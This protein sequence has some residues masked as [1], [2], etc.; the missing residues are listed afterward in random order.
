MSMSMLRLAVVLACCGFCNFCVQSDDETANPAKD[1]NRLAYLDECN[2]WYPHTN[3][4][5]LITPQWVGEE[6]VEAV[7]VLGIDDMRDT[8]KYEQYLRPILN[9]LKQIDGRAPVS[10]MTCDVKPDDPQL[11]SWLGEGLS[12]ECHTID[13]PCPIL[14]GGDG[15]FA[16]AK[17]TYDRC[18][19]L[20]GTIPGNKP[21]AFRTPCCDSLNTVS[22]RFFAEIFDGTNENGNFLQIDSSVFTFFTSE[23][24]SLPKELVL[25]ANGKERFWKYLPK[26]NKYGGNV[27]N[28]FVNYIKNYPYP[29]VINNSCWEIPC[30]APSDWSAQHL[31]GANNPTTV[32]DWKA[33]IDL[34]VHKQGCFSLVFHPHG[35]ISPEQV[36]EMIDHAV[37]KHGKKVKFLNFREVAERLNKHLLH[38][39]DN[40]RQLDEEY[41]LVDINDDG[42]IDVVHGGKGRMG[43]SEEERSESPPMMWT[44]NTSRWESLPFPSR[45]VSQMAGSL[46][47]AD[48]VRFMTLGAE[49]PMCILDVGSAKDSSRPWAELWRFDDTWK[50]SRINVGMREHLENYTNPDLITL[51][52]NGDSNDEILLTAEISDPDQWPEYGFAEVWRFNP[53]T[54]RW[55]S[56]ESPF[57][58]DIKRFSLAATKFI[59]IND[60][61][62]LDLVVSDGDFLGVWLMRSLEKGWLQQDQI[63][64]SPEK[65]WPFWRMG[66]CSFA[67]PWII[68]DCPRTNGFFIH[69]RHFCWINEDTATLPD[70][71]YRVSFDEILAEHKKASGRAA[72]IRGDAQVDDEENAHGGLTPNRSPKYE[73]VPVGAAVVDITPEYPVRLTGYGNRMKESEGVAARI[74][75][76]AMVIWG[77]AELEATAAIQSP[78]SPVERLNTSTRSPTGERARVR[79]K[80]EN[81]GATSHAEAQTPASSPLIRPSATFSPDLGGE[82]TSAAAQSSFP[83]PQSSLIILITVDNCGVPIEITEAVFAKLKEKHGLSRERFAISSTH[84][85]SAPWLRGFAPNIFDAI[86]DDH[87]AHLAQYEAELIEKLVEVVDKAIAARRPGHLSSGFG[88]TGFAMNR[89]LLANGKWTTFG[90]VPDG[91]TDKRVPVLAAHDTDGKLIAVLANYACHCTTETGEFNQISGDWAGFAADML[92]ADHPGAVAL[93]AIG[94]G[95]DANPS[96]RGT[97]DQAKVHGRTMAD[98]VKRVLA[99]GRASALRDDAH[100]EG[101]ENAL[102]GLTPNRSP[103]AVLH[104]INP[105]IHCRMARIDLPLGPLPSRADWEQ[106]ATQPGVTG[107]RARYFLKMLDEGKEIPSTIPDYP[108]QTWCFGDDLAMV[109]LGGEVVVDYSIRMNDMFDSDRLWINAY[110]NDV[111]C[112]IASARVLREGGYEADSSMLYYRRPTRLAPEAED[113]L[114]DAVQKLMPHEFYSEALQRD[115]PAPKSPEESLKCM[116]TKPNL[117]VVLAASE[118]LIRDPVAFDWDERGRLWVVEMGDYPEG[119]FGIQDSGVGKS[120]TDPGVTESRIPNPESSSGRVQMLEDT[121]KDGVYDKATTFLDGLAFPNGIHCWRGGV[122]ITM[123]PEIFYAEDTDGDGSADVRETLY[124][125]FVEGNQQHRVNGLRWG[126]DGWLYLANGDS[127]GEIVGTGFRTQESGSSKSQNGPAESRILNAES[128]RLSLRGRDLRIHPDSNGLDTVSG[129]TQFGRERDDFGN[130]FGNNNSNPIYQYVLEDRYVR[131]NPHAGISQVTAQVATIPGAAP[132][133]PTSRTLARFNDFAYANRFTSAC[134][135]MIYRD[136]YLGEQYYGNAFTSEPVHNLVSRLVLTRDGYGFKGERAADE[137]ESEFLASS[138]NW[139]RP[140][141]IRTGPDGAIWVADMYRAVIEH[142][143]WIPPEYQRKMNLYAGND[144]GRIYRIVPANECCGTESSASGRAS[145]LRDN[146]VETEQNGV[147][148]QNTHGGLTPSRSPEP[149]ITPVAEA[150]IV[151]TGQAASADASERTRLISTERD[152]YFEKPWNEIPIADLVKR[153]ESP[154]GWSRDTAQRILVHRKTELDGMPDSE[155]EDGSLVGYRVMGFLFESKNIAVQAHAAATLRSLHAHGETS[156]ILAE[157]PRILEHPDPQI[158]RL[159]VESLEFDFRDLDFFEKTPRVLRLLKPI[160]DDPDHGV[161]LQ[162]LLSLGE[163]KGDAGAALLGE[164]LRRN[165]ET[166]MLRSA[167]LTSLTPDNIGGVLNEALNV[168]AAELNEELIGVLLAQA[169]AMGRSEQLSEPLT[170]LVHSV[171]LDS[172]ASRFELLAGTLSNILNSDAAGSLKTNDTFQKAISAAHAI[173]ARIAGGNDIDADRRAA[174]V[175]FAGVT[176]SYGK[177][178]SLDLSDLLTARTPIPVQIAAV[179]VMGR[180][181]TQDSVTQLL[182]HWNSFAP[183]VRA[184]VLAT[185]LQRESTVQLLLDA[186]E[187]GSLAA[188]DFDAVQRDGLLNHQSGEIAK[189]ARSLFGEETP[190]PR[191]AVVDNFK[192]QISNLESEMTL[193]AKVAAGKLVFEKRCSA[194]HRLQDVGKEVGADLAALK[195]RSTE[196]LLTAV[197]DPNRAVESKFLVYTVVTKDGLQHS[198]ILKGETG[199]SLTLIGSDGKEITV[200]R[201]DIEELVASKRSLMPEGLEK[202]I[203]A[204]DLANLFAFVQSTG[205]PWKRFQG[206]SPQFVAANADGTVTLP[207]A[208][209]EIYGPNLV[210]EEKYGNLGFWSSTEDYAK[211]TFEVP[212]SGHWTVEFDFACDNATAGSLIKFSTGNRMLTARVPGS[213]TWDNYQTWQAGTIDLHRGRG[214]LIITAPENPPFAL[215]DLRA[216]RLIPP[217]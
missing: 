211:W 123:A 144:K 171:T 46:P 83:D 5:K 181:A 29:Y 21:V 39:G 60:D 152:G 11:Q 12:I 172:P 31:H 194:C 99:S 206:N 122:I 159:A 45:F 71:M 168:P 36:V 13:H 52:L 65:L 201:A 167:G 188:T 119:G 190:S 114:C 86:P 37:A 155:F 142:P 28:N 44:W 93:I 35:W 108:V 82:G 72:A 80:V 112:Y 191:A 141:M 61:R 69:D 202:D 22:P 157:Y 148:Q 177:D 127:G 149:S 121:D 217:K 179:R 204:Q 103:E 198:G 137:Q 100:G 160:V 111:P 40:F 207:A 113:V 150:E 176:S 56:V 154:N 173:A 115:F 205:T 209:A 104:P 57:P 33:A 77:K 74:H 109:F 145:A 94:C 183:I 17:S 43:E 79:G 174:A 55:E 208:A 8:A 10:I 30:L 102:G 175:R 53:T 118:P 105:N 151:S 130:W 27:H 193:D 24:E 42:F 212:R 14:Q 95:A 19:D 88:E 129:Q 133:Y 62:L 134:S 214:Q 182:S 47:H 196:A 51:D 110:S 138:D 135:T 178:S 6:G 143:E 161:R 41:K 3:F 156:D 54:D 126:L 66:K 199:G 70:L 76:R 120:Q 162:L 90:E 164:M 210:F 59:D 131:R 140:T 16:K 203:S 18:V 125:G 50:P 75:A 73:P 67:H 15:A 101:E 38:A 84:S 20:I 215:I 117:K 7:I 187:A 87:A 106:Q 2:P 91:P 78:L 184:E 81:T 124:Q 49:R 85:H 9:R 158:R 169:A 23:D 25:D 195:D 180:N 166:P 192:S 4:P 185:L 186:V 34:T 189:N 98:E 163:A 153:L 32:E 107:S 139:F 26:N 170:V 146:G 97:H 48:R 147:G 63:T 1:G 128:P 200:V 89:R 213:G 165:F 216:I 92:E 68:D 96:P 64:V 116:T 197:L 58:G 132:V 136:N